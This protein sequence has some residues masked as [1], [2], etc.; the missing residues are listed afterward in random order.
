MGD[1]DLPKAVQVLMMVVFLAILLLMCSESATALCPIVQTQKL[2]LAEG[3]FLLSTTQLVAKGTI[4]QAS[5]P[6]Q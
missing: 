4:R 3:L 1:M 6:Y 2:N 5:N